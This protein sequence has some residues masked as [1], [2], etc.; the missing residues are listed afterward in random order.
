[1]IRLTGLI[2]SRH[3]YIPMVL[4]ILGNHP[5]NVDGNSFISSFKQWL[6]DSFVQDWNS[7]LM[8]N[9]VLFVYKNVK[10]DFVYEDYLSVVSSKRYRH[11]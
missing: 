8:N 4:V 2:M 11:V 5:L 3:N 6:I 7:N 9:S 10:H 1:M